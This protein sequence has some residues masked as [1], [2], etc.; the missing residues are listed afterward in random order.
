MFARRWLCQAE[1]PPAR[2]WVS[3]GDV[4]VWHV[5]RALL[6]GLSLISSKKS[7][8]ARMGLGW[9][10]SAERFPPGSPQFS[11]ARAAPGWVLGCLPGVHVPYKVLMQPWGVLCPTP[12]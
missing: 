9:M 2:P 6:D 5:R 10:L 1:E 7:K 8:E 11:A 4:L 3:Q 12:R